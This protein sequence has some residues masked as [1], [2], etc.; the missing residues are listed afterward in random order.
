MEWKSVTEKPS[1][2]DTEPPVPTMANDPNNR[3]RPS[4]H[5]AGDF[6]PHLPYKHFKRERPLSQQQILFIFFYPQ[7]IV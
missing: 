6:E 4:H 1:G 7:A 3:N 2:S 5:W